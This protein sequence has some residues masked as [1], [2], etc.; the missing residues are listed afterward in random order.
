M[1]Q[2]SRFISY[3]GAGSGATEQSSRDKMGCATGTDHQPLQ[4]R[5][6]VRSLHRQPPQTTGRTW[7]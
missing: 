5:H 1:T 3:A 4:H 6:H 2:R 7:Q